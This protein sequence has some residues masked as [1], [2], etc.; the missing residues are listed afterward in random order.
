MMP[1]F[2]ANVCSIRSVYNGQV[3]ACS[4][5]IDISRSTIKDSSEG[6][7]GVDKGLYINK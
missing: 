4:R 5:N 6:Y 3:T 1:V 7:D 2:G